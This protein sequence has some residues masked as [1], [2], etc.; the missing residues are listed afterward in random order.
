MPR[1]APGWERAFLVLAAAL[2]AASVAATLGRT[3]MALDALSAFQVHFAVLA[4]AVAAVSVLRRAWRG[5]VLAV[6][7]AAVALIAAPQIWRSADQPAAP[8]PADSLTVAV[9]NVFYDN[10]E[11]EALAA[12]L[13]ALDADVLATLETPAALLSHPAL[14]AA[15]PHR[16]GWT[17]PDVPGG[18]AI[19]SRLPLLDRPR[20]SGGGHPNHLI[21][22]LDLGEGRPLEVLALH[23]DWPIVGG[24]GWQYEDFARFWSKVG[25]PLVVMGDFNAAPWSAMTRRVERITRT[26]VLDGWRPTFFGGSGGRSGRFWTPLGLPI[27][28]ILVSPGI[29]AAE[30]RTQALPGADHR[31]V[32]A[33]LTVPTARP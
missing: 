29:G 13:V 11:P 28:H 23:L 18:P 20:D 10:P 4:G 27:D 14:V 3:P 2:L 30:V 7:A 25:E 17:A 19:W 32:I 6:A 5:A 15:Y 22:T 9:A 1:P 33:R 12:A 26:E 31:A 8:G 24:Q 16:R 21:A